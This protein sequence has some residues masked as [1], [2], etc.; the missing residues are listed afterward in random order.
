MERQQKNEVDVKN[1]INEGQFETEPARLQAVPV[2]EHPVPQE[3]PGRKCRMSVWKLASCDGCQLSILD[4]EAELL[5]LAGSVEIAFFLEASSHIRPGPYDLAL[6]EGSVTTEED[7]L[8]LKEIRAQSRVLVAIG[9]CATA[10]G[11]QA[12]RND[13]SL[14]EIRRAVYPQPGTI[15]CLAESTPVSHHVKVDYELH[16]CPINK[17][18]LLEVIISVLR[19]KKP[20][21]L[22]ESVCME[23][24]RAQNECVMVTRGL[25]CLGPVTHAGCGALCPRMHRGCYGCY[26]AKEKAQTLSL[27]ER[28]RHEG[29]SPDA[30]ARL[31]Q[32]FNALS[33]PFQ[34]AWRRSLADQGE[35]RLGGRGEREQS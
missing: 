2:H 9:A 23:C 14:D 7:A 33:E 19:A 31:Y 22:N 27:A 15:G 13:K 21:I 26:G 4:L 20:A 29:S 10:G 17:H 32:S 12:L 28:F 16:G 18:Q 34:R 5:A 30:I 35:Q 8:R 1:E 6:V 25:P 3:E 24:K 11:I